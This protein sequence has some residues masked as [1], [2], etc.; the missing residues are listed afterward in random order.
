MKFST[1]NKYLLLGILSM[2]FLSYYFALRNTLV[3]RKEFKENLDKTEF[4]S[5]LPE[6]LSKLSLREKELDAHLGAMDLSSSSAHNNLLKFMNAEALKNQFKI[7]DFSAPHIVKFDKG[8]VETHQLHLE[9]SYI[10]ILKTLNTLEN[11]GSFGAIS[12]LSFQ[13]KKDF[14]SGRT[15]LRA[16]VFLEQTK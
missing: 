11:K 8:A 15:Y 3:V 2:F 7:I 14:R 10:S 13:K 4:F 5:N 9:G 6:Q 16:Q 1:K 12:H